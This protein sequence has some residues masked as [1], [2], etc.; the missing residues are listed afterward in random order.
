[1]A[2]RGESLYFIGADGV[3][4]IKVGKSKSPAA[5]LR[6]LSAG[7]PYKLRLLR[8]YEA[9]GRLEY[10]I[11]AAL[12]QRVPMNG[13]WFLGTDLDFDTLVRE[14]RHAQEAHGLPL[15]SSTEPRTRGLGFDITQAR[16]AKG[17]SQMD[18]QRITGLSQKY[19]SE[20]ERGKVSPRFDVVRRIAKALE[21]SLD[22]LGHEECFDG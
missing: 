21:V 1:M 20:I 7:S 16:K 10:Y 12:R 14:A 22:T 17:L 18:L 8:T 2:T 11:L 13:E 4:F 5:R 15:P 6:Q 19:L 3:D 9:E